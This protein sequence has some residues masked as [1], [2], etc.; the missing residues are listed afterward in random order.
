MKKIFAAGLCAALF[1]GLAACGQTSTDGG[2]FTPVPVV[3]TSLQRAEESSL[4]YI[5]DYTVLLETLDKAVG[6][7][8]GERPAVV[9][10][11]SNAVDGAVSPEESRGD[12]SRT[13][14]QVEGVDE[15]DIVKTDG[16]YI[17]VLSGYELKIFT[18]SGPDSAAVASLVLGYDKSADGAQSWSY[19]G[20][21][22]KQLYISGDR[23]VVLSDC[24]SARNYAGADSIWKYDSGSRTVIDIYDVANPA[25]PVLLG[26]LGQD[27]GMNDSRMIDGKIY[28]IS[29][30]SVYDY[31][32]TDP[33]TYVPRVYKGAESN[34]IP[35]DCIS[36]MPRPLGSS[37]AVIG[38]Y[39]VKSA[40]LTDSQTVLGVGDTVYMNKDSLYLSAWSETLTEA[41]PRTESV[42]SVVD[43]SRRSETQLC[44]FVIGA[45]GTLT[46][47][48]VATVQG[49]I[50]NQFS[51]DEYAGRLRVVTTISG[52]DYSLY[53]DAERGFE[54]YRDGKPFESNAALY[55]IDAETMQPLGSIAGL[56]PGEQVYSVRFDG[57]WAY[58]CTYKTVDPLFAVDVSQ[59]NAPRVMSELKISGFS[60]YL[61]LWSDGLL[62]GLGRETAKT[63]A[64]DDADDAETTEGMKLVMFDVSD[65]AAVSAKSELTI[66]EDWSEALYNHKAILIDSEK[67]I[68]GFP[69]GSGY[70]IYGWTAE[71]GFFL[72]AR[73]E[74]ASNWS[75]GMR[76]IYVGD[77]VYV[78]DDA[79]ITIVNLTSFILS[80]KL[81]F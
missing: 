31:D 25:L 41:A 42:Y 56:A 60:E 22:P 74:T 46:P 10:T 51:M 7:G 13:N 52:Y 33:Q 79:G 50:D 63:P 47:G 44:R 24:Y 23:L 38:V 30:Y 17:Y 19:E 76:G 77:Y 37:Y 64:A 67:N 65:K 21:N 2:K 80:A 59:P 69:A 54:N 4:I 62:F 55:V 48:A 26:T 36:V 27:G 81:V 58:F 73:V 1:L 68:I 15:G 45:D 75:G 53:K 8:G 66:Q 9:L 20:K 72:R 29:D 78:I 28:L 12:Y 40:A 39:D 5:N 71:Q 6:S 18:A 61:Q 11:P 70:D 3:P 32:R 49:Y 43:Y 57:D 16:S 34:V 14:A 35:A